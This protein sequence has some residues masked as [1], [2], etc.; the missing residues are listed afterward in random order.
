M[1]KM[2]TKFIKIKRYPLKRE[3]LRGVSVLLAAVS[4]SSAAAGGSLEQ[5][6]AAYITGYGYWDNTPPGSSTISHPRK[7]RRAGG[8]GTFNDPITIAVGHTLNGRRDVLDMPAGTK[9]YLRR[10]KKYA[11]VEDTCGD[12]SAPQNGPCHT[13]FRGHIWLDLWVGGKHSSAAS[14]ANCQ[15]RITALQMIV[16][17]PASNYEVYPGDVIESGC[18]VF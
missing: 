12:G 1:F 16:I 2:F 15:S 13:G 4:F 8:T 5:N 9:F 17:N 6:V 3:L 7:H 11:I 10:L 18:K 14:S